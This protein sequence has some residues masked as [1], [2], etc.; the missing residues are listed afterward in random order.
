M[1]ERNGEE[2][3]KKYVNK[4]PINLFYFL[5]QKY[6]HMR[7][8][9]PRKFLMGYNKHMTYSCENCLIS[10]SATIEVYTIQGSVVACALLPFNSGLKSTDSETMPAVFPALPLSPH[11]WPSF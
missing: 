8:P 11:Q 10:A 5:G 7:E 4:L 9:I 2:L 1:N 3:G 6:R